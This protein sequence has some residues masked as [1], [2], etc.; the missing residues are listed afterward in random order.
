MAVIVAGM[1]V[2]KC[3]NECYLAAGYGC[4]I[5]CQIMTTK[6]ME[7]KPDDCPVKSMDGLIDAIKTG[8]A[9]RCKDTAGNIFTLNDHI[10][11]II[12][13]YCEEWEGRK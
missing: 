1:Y 4:E 6:E 10:F 11:D 2:P 9:L 7:S 8:E 12:K 13:E 3:C 5:K